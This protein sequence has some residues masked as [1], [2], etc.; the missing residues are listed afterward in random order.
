M[1]SGI[2]VNVAMRRQ[3]AQVAAACGRGT[4]LRL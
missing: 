3:R 4:E 2:P 1:K